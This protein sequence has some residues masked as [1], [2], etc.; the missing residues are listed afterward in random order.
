MS[1]NFE[2]LEQIGKHQEIF[3][4]PGPSQAAFAEPIPAPAP[5]PSASLAPSVDKPGIEEVIALVQRVFLVSGD[6]AARRVVFAGSEPD[7][8]CSWMCAR[9]AEALASRVSGTVCMVDANLRTPTLHVQTGIANHHGLSDA[10]LD[11]SPVGGFITQLSSNLAIVSCGSAPKKAQGFLTSNR[12][13]ARLSELHSMFNYV[14]VDAPAMNGSRA[15][16]ILGGASDG[17][18][19]ILKAN[20]SRR[21]T[22][23]G[24][25]REFQ[26]AKVRVLG[27]VLNQRKFPIPES[28]YNKL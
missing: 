10:L 21:E 18:V 12:M 23:R 6:G 1:K 8:G 26:T 19:L 3:N 4:S 5:R 28:I 7:S 13:L 11:P 9:A 24:A 22:A 2:L 25:V 14:L 20:S 27:A 15:A 17:V 16:V